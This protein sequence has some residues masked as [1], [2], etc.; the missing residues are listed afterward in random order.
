MFDEFVG[1]VEVV[2]GKEGL[3]EEI[4]GFWELGEGI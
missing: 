4:N 1:D 2:V 3:V